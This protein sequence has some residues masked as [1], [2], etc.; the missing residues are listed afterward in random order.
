MMGGPVIHWLVKEQCVGE[1]RERKYNNKS[2]VWCG[3]LKN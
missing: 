3:K 2:G 1:N